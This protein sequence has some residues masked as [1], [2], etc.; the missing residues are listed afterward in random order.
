[1]C[2]EWGKKS[3]IN[4]TITGGRSGG[5]VPTNV[6]WEGN[7]SL[8]TT[9]TTRNNGCVISLAAA[10]HKPEIFCHQTTNSAS[11]AAAAIL[12][13]LHLQPHVDVS[14]QAANFKLA[15]KWFWNLSWH[16]KLALGNNRNWQQLSGETSQTSL[17]VE[18]VSQQ[19][20]RSYQQTWENRALTVKVFD[21]GLTQIL[22]QDY[23][24]VLVL[25]LN[26]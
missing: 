22:T 4:N 9:Q 12:P 26:C 3:D 5:G 18:T 2:W 6:W 16:G 1:M 23:Y 25:A 8:A 15:N 24:T 17:C 10:H 7:V 21:W 14:L 11:G 20:P 19:T 13:N